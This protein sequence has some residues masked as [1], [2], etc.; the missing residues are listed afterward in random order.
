MAKQES[1]PVSPVPPLGSLCVGSV[2][3]RSDLHDRF[4]GNR[5]KGI[6][7][8][9]R[10]SVI[11]L[12]HTRE[13]SRQFYS[14]GVDEDGIYWFSGEG[15]IGD[16][17]WNSENTQ[18]RDA[19]ETPRSL[20]L[21]ERYRRAGGLWSFYG[22]MFCLGHKEVTQSDENGQ[23]RRA[24]VFALA[25][26]VDAGSLGHDKDRTSF[27]ATSLSLGS[28]RDMAIG[29][30]PAAGSAGRRM[31]MATFFL[32]SEAIRQYA[33]QRANG[34]CEACNDP[35]AFQANWG[36]YLEVHHLSRLADGGPDHPDRVAAV[37]ANCHRRCHYGTDRVAYNALLSKAIARKE[38]ER[39]AV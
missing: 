39:D 33:L 20:L 22:E 12:F 25:R 23:A 24:F 28:L 3:A 4:A 6:S 15:R 11:L 36:P 34:L 29:T 16:M 35:A 7:V 2:F 8:S 13:P 32:R 1:E 37:C 5:Q 38:A 17:Q 26:I 14:D 30:K 9:T 27:E 31:S 10:E 19:A 21:F 18:L